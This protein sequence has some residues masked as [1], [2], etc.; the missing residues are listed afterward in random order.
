MTQNT[1][2]GGEKALFLGREGGFLEFFGIFWKSFERCAK[3]GH[4]WA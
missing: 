1:P 4:K 3:A 2:F